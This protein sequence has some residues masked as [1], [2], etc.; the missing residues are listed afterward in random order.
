MRGLGIPA[1]FTRPAPA[2]LITELKLISLGLVAQSSSSKTCTAHGHWA[3]QAAMP[4]LKLTT[5]SG[6]EAST[7]GD[8]G[9]HMHVEI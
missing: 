7:L 8:R 3:A 9:D 1:G 2:A 5:S 4:L 6:A